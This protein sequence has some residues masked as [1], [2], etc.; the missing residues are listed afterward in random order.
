MKSPQQSYYV[1]R[2]MKVSFSLANSKTKAAKAVG[3]APPLKKPAAF[4]SLGDDD[5]L[6]A[7]PIVKNKDGVPVSKQLLA[8][9]AGMSKSLKRKLEEEK[10]IDSTV[11]EYDEVWDKMQEAK[12]KQKEVKELDSKERKV[13]YIPCIMRGMTNGISYVAQIHKWSTA[14]CGDP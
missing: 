6:D 2:I 8:Q 3:E 12:Q 5:P 1:T 4:A 14:V 13:C 9:H 11:F 7:A 10:K